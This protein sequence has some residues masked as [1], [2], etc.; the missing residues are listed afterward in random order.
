MWITTLD[1]YYSVVEVRDNE[2]RL[3][4]RAR[5]RRD[6]DRLLDR[7]PWRFR[8]WRALA[9]WPGPTH[10]P[11]ADYPWRVLM[12]RSA[13]GGYLARAARDLDYGNFKA[14][15]HATGVRGP[16]RARI[17]GRVWDNL[18]DL[19]PDRAA[20]M[21]GAWDRNPLDAPPDLPPVPGQLDQRELRLVASLGVAEF[22]PYRLPDSR[23]HAP[24]S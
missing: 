16:K 15:V 19:E 3:F 4:V 22:D 6:L 17:Y 10:T 2:D 7:L 23:E 9:G 5:D 21:V 11:D 8:A 14:A 24:P 12:S 18:L 20:R 1:G 13:V